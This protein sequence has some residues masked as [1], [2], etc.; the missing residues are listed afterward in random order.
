MKSTKLF[1]LA[2]ALC[3]YGESQ[4]LGSS[5]DEKELSSAELFK[6]QYEQRQ[7]KLRKEIPSGVVYIEQSEKSPSVFCVM[8][9]NEDGSVSESTVLPKGTSIPKTTSYEKFYS[10]C[11]DYGKYL[12]GVFIPKKSNDSDIWYPGQFLIFFLKLDFKA[13]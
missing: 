5:G 12:Y 4:I 6:K 1:I 3:M 13:V 9:K 10:E 7:A 2:F 8:T 11:C